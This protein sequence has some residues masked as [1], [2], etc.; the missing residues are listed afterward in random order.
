MKW[1]LDVDVLCALAWES[2]ERR[3]EARQWLDGGAKV[4]TSPISELGFLRVSLRAHGA[5]FSDAVAA[6][7]DITHR[8][9]FIS[10]AVRVADLPECTPGQSTD[11]HLVV[12]A[13]HHKLKLATFDNGLANQSWAKG[14]AENPLVRG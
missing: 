14:V 1:L 7:T 6:L 5:R 10:D 4:V 3:K 2:H 13:R 12:L 9:G 11:A 8:A